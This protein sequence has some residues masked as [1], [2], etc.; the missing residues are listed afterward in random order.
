MGAK[1]L[2]PDLKH[3]KECGSLNRTLPGLII[4]LLMTDRVVVGDSLMPGIK[5]RIPPLRVCHFTSAIVFPNL[6]S[7]LVV[8]KVSPSSDPSQMNDSPAFQTPVAADR[9]ISRQGHKSIYAS[10][11]GKTLQ[12]RGSR[13]ARGRWGGWSSLKL[14]LAVA[15]G[16]SDS[17]DCVVV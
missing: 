6:N 10:S 12:N 15:R 8:D 7:S 5:L 13:L 17:H 4:L 9:H 3:G 11:A 1:N 14:H 16:N 2:K